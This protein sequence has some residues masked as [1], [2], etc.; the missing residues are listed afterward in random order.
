MIGSLT[1]LCTYCGGCVCVCPSG[2]L[3]L[4][5]TR[6]V[7][8]DGLCNTCVLCIQACPAGALTVEGEAPRLSSVRQKY[9][10]VVVGAG[11][12]GSTAARLA[13]ERG[14]DVLMLEKRQEIGSPVRCAEG[15]NREML[16]PF[17]EPEER[18]ISAKVNRSQIVTVD[19]GEAHLF[20][21][22]EM[23][24]VLERR[25]LDRALAERAVAAGV[26]VMVKTAVEGLIME[27]G[28]TRGVEATSGR[29]R[30]EIEAQVV[31]GADG[32][33]AKV[34]QWSGL[35]CIL[36]QQDCLVCA[37][38]LLAGIDVDPGSCY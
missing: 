36:P 22:D 37:Q 28:V 29:T 38:F 14:L 20:V 13:A 16:L 2:A 23:G 27:D 7:I 26:Q 12:A 15:I 11:P 10:L 32:T 34:G 21:G 18:W 3:E 9:D 17:L 5:E 25:V 35:E 19:T 31:I 30:F 8:D 33:E 24:Y 4:A 6:L 1:A